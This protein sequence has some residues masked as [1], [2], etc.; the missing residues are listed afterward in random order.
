MFLFEGGKAAG[1]GAGGAA[2][3]DGSSYAAFV[4]LRGDRRGGIGSCQLRRTRACPS[5]TSR[6]PLA[7]LPRVLQVR[8]LSAAHAG[9]VWQ[10]SR[11]KPGLQRSRLK[12]G[13]QPNGRKSQNRPAC[14]NRT[15]A[16]AGRRGTASACSSRERKYHC[17]GNKWGTASICSNRARRCRCRAGR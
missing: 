2:S 1:G 12:P 4:T 14:S 13:L 10:R 9:R 17:R 5:L 11:L 16:R 6:S 8:K 15:P 7:S 3:G